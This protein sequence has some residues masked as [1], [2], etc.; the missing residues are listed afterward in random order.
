M[1]LGHISFP[2]IRTS[3]CLLLRYNAGTLNYLGQL[4]ETM[5]RVTGIEPVYPAWKAGA[6]ADVLHPQMW[7]GLSTLPIYYIT[8]FQK[9]QNFMVPPS[10]IEP[11]T[12]TL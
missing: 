6:L 4:Q 1:L 9:S 12:S 10:G 8:D 5:E 7:V 2:R 3:Q 11:L